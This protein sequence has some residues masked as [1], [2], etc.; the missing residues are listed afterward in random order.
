MLRTL[1]RIGVFLVLA[2][3]GTLANAAPYG[4][5]PSEHR[6]RRNSERLES[7]AKDVLRNNKKECSVVRDAHEERDE[8]IVV[9]CLSKDKLR[10]LRYVITPSNGQ[11]GAKVS[12]VS[13]QH[14]KNTKLRDGQHLD[15]R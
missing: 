5:G 12:L 8:K 7:Y 11:R 4:P 15:S 2:C 10:E 1:N 9:D 3:A 6:E 14:N 13:N